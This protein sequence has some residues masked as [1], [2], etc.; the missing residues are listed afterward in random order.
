MRRV[1]F[2]IR[3]KLLDEIHTDLS[4]PHDFAAERVGFIACTLADFPAG[5]IAVLAQTYLSLRDDH[6]EDDPSVGAMMN[7]DAIRLALQYSYNNRAGM[8]HVHRHDHHGVPGFSF[9]DL[10]EADKFVPDF[11]KVQPRLIHGAIV[12]SHDRMH[13][14]WWNRKTKHARPIDEWAVVGFPT[15]SHEEPRHEAGFE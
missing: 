3:R 4:R 2:K 15:T 11:W 5:E 9:V 12:L 8:F 6:Y 7:A 1:T 13:G 10:R 14:R